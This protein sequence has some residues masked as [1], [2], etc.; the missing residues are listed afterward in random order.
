MGTMIKYSRRRRAVTA[1][2]SVCSILF[3]CSMA[4]TVTRAACAELPKFIESARNPNSE[5]QRTEVPLDLAQSDTAPRSQREATTPYQKQAAAKDVPASRDS[6]FG[7]DA[8]AAIPPKSP[9]P[10]SRDSLFGDD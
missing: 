4:L 3:A 6:L 7:D 5:L 2:R 9:P 8:P 10:T 1:L